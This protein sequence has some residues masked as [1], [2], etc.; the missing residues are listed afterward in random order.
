MIPRNLGFFLEMSSILQRRFPVAG[1]KT[2]DCLVF[3][4]LQTIVLLASLGFLA[5][6]LQ[7][8]V[9]SGS[10]PGSDFSFL[11]IAAKI[12]S[13]QDLRLAY[14]GELFSL[15]AVQQQHWEAPA[16]GNYFAYPPHFLLFF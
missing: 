4:V 10:V 5:F 7:R 14:S 2:A 11:W 12:A 15:E 13:A 9:A 16:R 8:Y 1:L 6:A 3:G